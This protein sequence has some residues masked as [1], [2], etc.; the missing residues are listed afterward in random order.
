MKRR[1]FFLV[2]TFA[3]MLCAVQFVNAQEQPVPTL[4]PPQDN[5]AQANQEPEVAPTDAPTDTPTDTSPSDVLLQEDAA[6]NQSVLD[7][8]NIDN[9]AAPSD[10]FAPPADGLI[11]QP[12]PDFVAPAGNQFGYVQPVQQPGYGCIPVVHGCHHCQQPVFVH[13]HH[14]FHSRPCHRPRRLF[15]FRR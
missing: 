5:Q 9:G 11:V 12:T 4:A 6:G 3:A 7:N 2:T 15:R 14:G 8:S 13:V 10:V 1:T